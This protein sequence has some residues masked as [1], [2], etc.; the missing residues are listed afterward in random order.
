MSAVEFDMNKYFQIMWIAAAIAAAWLIA[1]LPNR[2]AAAAI[3]ISMLSPA[4]IAIH[5]ATHPAVVMSLAQEAAGEWIETHT[6]DR[7]VFATDDFIN[8]PVDLAGR[9]RIT[10]FGPYVS[11]FGYDPEPR[12]ADINAIYCDGPQVARERMAKYEATY[13]LSA[14]GVLDCEQPTDFGASPLFETVYSAAGVSVWRI[15]GT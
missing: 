7:A 10:T 9:L 13:V 8:S 15:A 4:L 3:A 5:H 2:L 11:N 1:R 14:G 12:A 6:P